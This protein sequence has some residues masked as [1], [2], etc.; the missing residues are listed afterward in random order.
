VSGATGGFIFGGPIGAGLGAGIA[1]AASLLGLTSNTRASRMQELDDVQALADALKYKEATELADEY[2]ARDRRFTLRKKSSA[3][4]AY[5]E[6]AY[7]G[8]VAGFNDVTGSLSPAERSYV[9]RMMLNMHKEDI[10]KIAPLLPAHTRG[11]FL[12]YATGEVPDTSIYQKYITDARRVV[13]GAPLRFRSDDIIYKTLQTRGLDA[14]ELGL[15]WTQQVNRVKYMENVRGMDIPT[16]DED[17]G[18][19][20]FI[21]KFGSVVRL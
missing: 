2:E 14:H 9:R 5:T 15:G 13:E 4:Y 3:Y 6:G 7:L 21:P 17:P 16:L 10:E 8:E 19:P 18:Y 12:S 1:G 20:G 11:L